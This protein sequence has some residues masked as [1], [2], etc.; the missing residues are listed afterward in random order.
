M[1]FT[2]PFITAY[3]LIVAG[4][5]GAVLGSFLNC[6]AWRVIHGD[7]VLK[8][9]SFCAYC[10]HTLSARDLI[11][12]VSY[13]ALR[14]KCR[15]CHRKLSPRFLLSE[16]AGAVIYITVLLR[17]DLSWECLRML[18]VLT[19]LLYASLAD[20]EGGWIP[21]RVWVCCV[22]G[23]FPLAYL[24]GGW[25]LIK[26]GMIG[27]VIVFVFLVTVVWLM[28]KVTGKDT[29]GGGD[30]KL[31]GVVGLYCGWPDFLFPVLISTI[32]GIIGLTVT[33]RMKKDLPIRFA[34]AIAASVW[35]DALF[36]DVAMEF[37]AS[38]YR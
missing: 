37:Y 31:F 27:G 38:L 11:P 35:L 22:I 26:N 10:Y 6:A 34:P 12:V 28:D 2:T 5:L 21:D 8:G 4:I 23:Y 20:L 13:V 9:R 3:C 29:M 19:W 15:Y 17:H 33:G 1:L 25:A 30:I 32:L 16:L 24:S 7:T 14:G 18:Y 36:G